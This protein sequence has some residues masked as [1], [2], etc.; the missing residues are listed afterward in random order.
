MKAKVLFT[1]FHEN[2]GEDPPARI[3]AD[4]KLFRNFFRNFIWG[5]NGDLK[6]TGTVS[7]LPISRETRTP[8]RS[9]STVK[10]ALKK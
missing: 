7:E 5:F 4:T 10:R 2:L 6:A 3:G 1:S 8:R 9:L